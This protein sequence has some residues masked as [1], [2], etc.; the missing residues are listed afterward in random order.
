MDRHN[1]K[2]NPPLPGTNDPPKFSVDR[3]GMIV[4]EFKDGMTL[5]SNS[6]ADHLRYAILHELQ[7]RRT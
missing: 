5:R 1:L 6:I 2:P 3:S 4:A 7:G